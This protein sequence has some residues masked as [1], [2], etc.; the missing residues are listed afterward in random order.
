MSHSPLPVTPSPHKEGCEEPYSSYSG[1]GGQDNLQLEFLGTGTSTGVPPL[2]CNC[3]VCR[4]TDPRDKRLRASAI[5]RYRG[6]SILIDCGPDFRQQMLR[7][8]DDQLDALL[9]THIHYDHVGGID[10]LRAYCFDRHF[11]VYA[12]QDVIDRLRERLPY[13]FA[14]N[15]YPGVPLLD[16]TAINDTDPFMVEGIEVQPIPVMHDQLPILGF[17]IGPLAYI[18]DCKTISDQQIDRLRG[19]P[20]LVINALR[21]KPHHS[22]MHLAATL[23]VIARINPGQAYLTHMADRIGFHA[24]IDKT[25]PQNVHLAYDQ[26]LITL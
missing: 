8:T 13:C 23:D 4:S 14:E 10:D 24:Q 11:P 15:P 7:A 22:H 16:C 9:L 6:K 18:T 26:L 3:E 5:V 25:L 21:H 17:R 20:L 19:I 12:R 1:I 2:R